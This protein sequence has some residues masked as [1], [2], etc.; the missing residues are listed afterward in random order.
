MTTIFVIDG[1]RPHIR[2][3]VRTS[4]QASAAGSVA[5]KLRACTQKQRAGQ[6][7]ILT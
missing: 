2:A 6:G 5:R 1:V 3:R 4:S 7:R